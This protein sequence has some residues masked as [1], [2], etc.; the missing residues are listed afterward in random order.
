[1]KILKAIFN[2]ITDS[3]IISIKK[4]RIFE[5][6]ERC[7]KWKIVFQKLKLINYFPFS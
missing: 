7:L 3:N 1:M 2:L 5:F 6:Q 4:V